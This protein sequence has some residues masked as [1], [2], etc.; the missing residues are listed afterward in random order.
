MHEA[1]ESPVANA[2]P[3][4]WPSLKG[5]GFSLK[6]TGFSL[7]GTGFSLKGTGFSLK[8]TGFSPYIKLTQINWD[9]AP[10]GMHSQSDHHPNLGK[11]IT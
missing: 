2:N 3:A 7:K 11:T 9:L 10:E 1:D 8:G 5:T 4:Q 6:G